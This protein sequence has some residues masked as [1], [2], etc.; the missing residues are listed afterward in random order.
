LVTN[1]Y[2]DEEGRG[3]YFPGS[4][5]TSEGQFLMTLGMLEAYQA[6]GNETA[7]SIANLALSP[8]LSV[9]YRNYPIPETVTDTDIFAP[10][11]LFNVK[12]S[13]VSAV[14]RYDDIFTFSNGVGVVPDTY[15]EVRY[16]FQALTP[17]YTLVYQSPYSPPASSALPTTFTSVWQYAYF[18][19]TDAPAPGTFYSAN[20]PGNVVTV[21]YG[22][23]TVGAAE[24]ATLVERFNSTTPTYVYVSFTGAAET[25]GP[26]VVQIT[27]IGLSQPPGN[28][29]YFWYFTYEVPNSA[30]TY[31][32][33]SGNEGYTAS[34]TVLPAG[35]GISYPI[36]SYVYN[37]AQGGT[38]VTLVDTAFSG[39]LAVIYSCLSGPIISTGEDFEA[40]P[41]WRPLADG[42]IDS[43][44][45]TY[46][47][48]YRTFTAASVTG[49]STWAQC[50]N[51]TLQQALVAYTVN[52]QRQW[53]APSIQLEPLSQSG[54]FFFT[55]NTPAPVL[56]CN[57]SGDIVISCTQQ[58]TAGTSTQFGVA[59]INDTFASGDTVTW[60]FSTA[61]TGGASGTCA[62][63]L[64]IDTTNQQPYVAANR[65]IYSVTANLGESNVLPLNL[66]NFSNGTTTLPAGSAVYTCGVQ[67]TGEM[68]VGLSVTI[69]SVVATPNISVA[70]EGGCIPFTANFLGDP[71]SIIGW[72]GPSYAGYQSP[73]MF[74]QLGNE[75]AV[76]TNVQF[77]HDAQAAWT[78]QATTKDVGPF[79]PVY[80]FDKPDSV[81]YGP[82]NTFGWTGPDPN[83]EWVG[84]EVRPL[85]ELAE[86]VAACTGTESYYALAV[87]VTNNFLTW[88]DANWP[89]ATVTAGP[90]SIFPQTGAQVTYPEPH[91]VSLIVR[92]ALKMDQATRP[93][94]NASGEM[95][96]TYA[97][98][99][100]KAV[101]F[102]SYWYQT[103]GVMA[104][105]FCYD[106]V[107]LTWYGFWHG[108]ILRTLSNLYTW[109]SS[110]AIDQPTTA[111]QALTWINGMVSWVSANTQEVYS[112][113]GY[114][115][116][117]LSGSIRWSP[118]LA[119]RDL[120]NGVMGT[121]ICE[122]NQFQITDFPYYAQDSTHGYDNAPAQYEGDANWEAD[123]ARLWK[124]VQLPFTT[125]SSM[126]QRIAKI[127]MLRGRQQGRGTL[128]GRMSMY[129][130]IP[131]DI[132]YFS[133]P[134]LGWSNKVLE[135]QTSRF[136][137]NTQSGA[138]VLGVEMDLQETD[139]SVYDWSVTEELS[140]QGYPQVA[141]A[142][143]AAPAPANTETISI[144]G[145]P[146]AAITT[147]YT[148][149]VNGTTVSTSNPNIGVAD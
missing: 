27:S 143:V 148:I 144:G 137:L 66:S 36:A 73:W 139:P 80:Y 89:T 24:D 68:P 88:L 55:D 72:Q 106:L 78:A 23:Y 5:G 130:S 94:G 61:T 31:Y 8:M 140:I 12:A 114:T 90:P 76:A 2:N 116:A 65:Y 33:G 32:T 4:A 123:G 43:A 60:S 141:S 132:I 108:E 64:Y 11:W 112:D 100:S 82:V 49:D 45:D 101:T 121:F 145:L 3:E 21:Y 1:S 17:G 110:A 79:A 67:I 40:F 102:W 125:S 120:Y 115:F 7:L 126:A 93:N 53:I 15:G 136:L 146:L 147:G 124:N 128:Q 47:W 134:Q 95:N 20:T 119:K 56:S 98:L 26:Y 97:S 127:E 103:T 71:A 117:D 48:A 54:A 18:L 46:N 50:A 104:G 133:M 109:A 58:P 87:T 69:D 39:E 91:A 59:S 25:Q 105:T 84:Y 22:D 34:F 28:P 111:A 35:F 10:H 19:Q 37:A 38:V 70:Y 142:I 16:V 63:E 42:E 135:V 44:C 52:N 74:K 122:S 149:S 6:T 138:P 9:L 118:K 107:G 96:A 113:L 85:A 57:Q 51:A 92:A 129:Q 30:Y 86:L 14:I 81:Q 13:F 131:L 99:L 77:L 75:T 83:T 62:V 29:H 41:D